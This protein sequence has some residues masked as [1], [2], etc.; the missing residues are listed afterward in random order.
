MKIAN[1]LHGFSLKDWS[2]LAVIILFWGAN[3]AVVKVGVNEIHPQLLIALRAFFTSIVFLPFARKVSMFD[4]RRLFAVAMIFV[5]LHF[6]CM[7]AALGFINSNSFVIL[8]AL[9]MPISILLSAVFLKERIGPWTIVGFVI[10]FCGLVVAFGL[11]DIKTYPLGAVLAVMTACLWATG[12][13]LM[14]RTKHIPLGNFVFYTYALATPVLFAVAY[15]MHGSDLFDFSDVDFTRLG[16]SL[17]YQVVVIGAMTAVWGYL[18][19]HHPAE[20][21][22]PFLMLQIPVA[23]MAGYVLLGEAVT[24]N[25]VVSSL[26]IIVGV[27]LIHYRRLKRLSR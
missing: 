26:F 10:C 12:S 7:Y 22:T 9:G 4:F 8:T 14:K 3:A 21:V 15:G 19:G 1:V 27:G 13:L 20:Y 16:G 25:F 2:L 18:I 23:A 17:F 5:A 6:T 11:P 24:P